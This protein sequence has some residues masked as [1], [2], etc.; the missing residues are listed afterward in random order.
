MAASY[1]NPS[2]RVPKPESQRRRRNQP[3]SYGDAKADW[4]RGRLEMFY[5]N[6]LLTGRR[7]LSPSA[8]STVQA[9]MNE[10]LLSPAIKRRAGVELKRAAGD[11][12]ADAA[13]M[14]GKYKQVLKSVP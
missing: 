4:E 3:K 2:G 11:A 14:V 6:A 9:G 12:D 8:W 13:A 5:A 7:Q 1:P 10:L